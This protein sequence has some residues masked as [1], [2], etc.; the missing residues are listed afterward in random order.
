MGTQGLSALAG[1]SCEID[2]VC[3]ELAAGLGSTAAHVRVN[4]TI[5]LLACDVIVATL[6]AWNEISVHH[7]IVYCSEWRVPAA[8]RSAMPYKIATV[9]ARSGSIKVAVARTATAAARAIL[10]DAHR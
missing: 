2:A 9:D 10:W 6:G 3:K 4:P 5:P 7:Y 1:A 8:W